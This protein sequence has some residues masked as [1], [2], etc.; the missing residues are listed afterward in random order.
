MFTVNRFWFCHL[1]ERR[2]CCS[3]GGTR[4]GQTPAAVASSSSR[5][6]VSSVRGASASVGR[7]TGAGRRLDGV[8]LRAG[9]VTEP[10][11]SQSG[12]CQS[13]THVLRFRRFVLRTRVLVQV[14]ALAVAVCTRS[15][16][17]RSE[18]GN[19]RRHRE[20][21][22]LTFSVRRFTQSHSFCQFTD[23]PANTRSTSGAVLIC[24]QAPVAV[25]HAP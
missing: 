20:D 5:A 19:V 8:S 7:S 22:H 3:S 4:P 6:Q 1:D 14:A 11:S 12:H 18:Q 24:P 15:R 13:L 2:R 10:G 25:V 17:T 21:E 9:G 23:P 16:D